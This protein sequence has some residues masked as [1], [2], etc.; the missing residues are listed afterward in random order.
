MSRVMKM[1]LDL[2]QVES[3]QKKK[4]ATPEC[5]PHLMAQ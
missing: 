5:V 1:T 2:R 4:A 3:V